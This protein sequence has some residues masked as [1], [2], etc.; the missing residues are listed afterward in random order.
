MIHAQ[1]FKLTNLE[2]TTSL[3]EKL[4]AHYQ[5]RLVILREKND[6]KLSAEETAHIRG[7]IQEVKQL[8][9]LAVPAPV[10]NS[11]D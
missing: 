2:V 1:P 5:K 11:G 8:L 6:G 7:Q 4:A 3:W 9:E 10:I